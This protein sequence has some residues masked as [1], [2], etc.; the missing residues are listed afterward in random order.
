MGGLWKNS[1]MLGLLLRACSRR[2]T[3]RS[4]S[5][6]SCGVLYVVLSFSIVLCRCSRSVVVVLFL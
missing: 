3:L 6:T 5:T 4:P 1:R 2:S